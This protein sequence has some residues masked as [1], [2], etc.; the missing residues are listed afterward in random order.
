[1][2]KEMEETVKKVQTN[3]NTLNIDRKLMPIG[4]GIL[5]NFI[6]ETTYMCKYELR[7]V[8]CNG[9]VVLN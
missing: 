9:E 4:S 7:Q 5:E 8:P 1:M 3:V 2:L 6:S